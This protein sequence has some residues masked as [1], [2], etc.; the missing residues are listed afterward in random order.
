ML[1]GFFRYQKGRFSLVMFDTKRDR[2]L[3]MKKRRSVIVIRLFLGLLAAGLFAMLLF[4]GIRRMGVVDLFGR[5]PVSPAFDNPLDTFDADSLPVFDGSPAVTL[6]D[7]VPAFTD[8]ELAASPGQTLSRLDSL[9]RCGPAFAVIT[10]EMMPAEP[11]GEIGQIRP[12]GWH[13]VKYPELIEDR[14]LYNRC[15][16]IAYALTGENA[17]EKNLITGTRFLNVEGMLPYE[18]QALRYLED[19]PAGRRLLYRVTP[20][21]IGQELVCRGVRMEAY[22]ADDGGRGCCF[23]VFVF[24]VQ[25]GIVIDYATGESRVE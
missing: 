21:F 20:V 7:G 16:L 3:S 5:R 8:E 19:A 6:G 1:S 15:H 11:R 18:R 23:D 9:G 4:W 17:N 14:Y 22:S 13:T 10:R 2:P 24:N 12:S 25:P